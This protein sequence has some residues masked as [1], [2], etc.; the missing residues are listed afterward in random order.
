ML[1]L[2]TFP[3]TEPNVTTKNKMSNS[4]KTKNPQIVLIETEKKSMH[5]N[6][7]CLTIQPWNM[8][9]ISTIQKHTEA[10][11]IITFLHA[12]YR[13]MSFSINGTKTTR[14]IISAALTYLD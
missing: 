13:R 7:L 12:F 6:K 14:R 1:D 4:Q 5:W 11:C 2:I 10:K 3:E 9:P 8:S